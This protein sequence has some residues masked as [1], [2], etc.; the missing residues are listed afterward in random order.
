[1]EDATVDFFYQRVDM[2]ANVDMPYETTITVN[3]DAGSGGQT[4]SVT[5][6]V[7]NLYQW[8]TDE[9]LTYNGWSSST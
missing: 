8:D 9:F 4:T 3:V 1:M 2:A 5:L 7:S 6:L